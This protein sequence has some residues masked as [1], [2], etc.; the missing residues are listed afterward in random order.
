MRVRWSVLVRASVAAL[1]GALVAG[2][3]AVGPETAECR[4]PLF[5]ADCVYAVAEARAA[6]GFNEDIKDLAE[7]GQIRLTEVW[8]ACSD[9]GC[10]DD[11]AGFAF[12]RMRTDD[13]DSLGRV[14]VCIDRA[15][16]GDQPP[17]FGFP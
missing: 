16:C 3:V 13:G 17:T 2:C 5:P 1:I 7:G 4:P 10:M 8:R 6:I 15:F 12:V 9:A 11:L 14:I